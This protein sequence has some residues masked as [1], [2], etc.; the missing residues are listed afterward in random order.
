[1]PPFDMWL[2]G[3][4]D[5]AGWFGEQRIAC[6]GSHL[7]PCDVHGTAGFA[8]YEPGDD[9]RLHPWT[10]RVIDVAAGRIVG[11]RSPGLGTS[12]RVAWSASP[13]LLTGSIRM[14]RW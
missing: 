10:I 13:G 4:S 14:L 1:M 2:Q 11:L 3:S 12:S 8:S 9:G 5:L 6:Q 7:P